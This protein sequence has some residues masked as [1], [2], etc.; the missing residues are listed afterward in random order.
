MWLGNQLDPEEW[1]WKLVNNVLEPMYTLLPPAPEHLLNT[2]FCNCKMGCN[3]K[4][5]YKQVG[6]LC[7]PACTNCQGNSCDNVESL[8]TEEDVAYND[9]DE[10]QEESTEEKEEQDEEEEE[11]EDC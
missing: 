2:I 9:V 6:L 1:G 11:E 10:L 4:C 7:S 3:S 8:L 5:G